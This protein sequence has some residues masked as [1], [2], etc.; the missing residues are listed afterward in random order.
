[1]GK[2]KKK[3]IE[4]SEILSEEE[5]IDFD[6]EED[7]DEIDDNEGFEDEDT[8]KKTATEYDDEPEDNTENEDEYDD[9][10]ISEPDVKNQFTIVKSNERITKPI[11]NKYERTRILATRTRQI[12]L[13]AKPLVKIEQ[14]LS[15]FEVAKLELKNKMTPLIIKRT[16]PSGKIEL[17]K[18]EELEDIYENDY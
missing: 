18:I 1:M 13:G 5:F 2:G 11:L 3:V 7:T 14:K 16:L 9:F 17:W 6:E 15:P 10:E 4:D 8:N 12:A